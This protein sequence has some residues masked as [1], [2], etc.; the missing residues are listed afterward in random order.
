MK[1]KRNYQKKEKFKIP[2]SY[3][4]EVYLH[5]FIF[6]GINSSFLPTK[7]QK[8]DF[9]EYFSHA[10]GMKNPPKIKILEI[11]LKEGEFLPRKF[12]KKEYDFFYG[13]FLEFL[14]Q[15]LSLFE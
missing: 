8:K 13:K 7:E 3:E 4:T 2:L 12:P 14:D 15:N 10:L 6:D 1:P 5:D 11:S 9:D